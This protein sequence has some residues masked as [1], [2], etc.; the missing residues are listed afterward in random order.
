MSLGLSDSLLIWMRTLLPAVCILSILFAL[1]AVRL[2]RRSAAARLTIIFLMLASWSFAG[3][4]GLIYPH[5]LGQ[6][7]PRDWMASAFATDFRHW[8]QDV[9]AA[10]FASHLR[11]GCRVLSS[12]LYAWSA[13]LRSSNEVVPLWSPEVRFIFDS[14]LPLAEIYERLARLRICAIWWEPDD[15][16]RFPVNRLYVDGPKDWTLLAQSGS[17][18]LYRLP[19]GNNPL[20]Q[21]K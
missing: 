6:T 2:F 21:T 7:P 17:G 11:P 18:Y 19:L 5:R 16:H 14:S 4:F 12:D 1:I 8:D 20:S 13:H 3:I 9:G 15:V 10:D